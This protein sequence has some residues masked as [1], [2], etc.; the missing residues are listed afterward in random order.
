MSA[1]GMS[2]AF[3]KVGRMDLNSRILKSSR[4]ITSGDDNWTSRS[5]LFVRGEKGG[6]KGGGEGWGWGL[7]SKGNQLHGFS[8]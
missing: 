4:C 7:D 3:I 2:S 8:R 5:I 6:E 1:W